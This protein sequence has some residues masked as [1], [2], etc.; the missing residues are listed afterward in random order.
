MEYF[1]QILHT[2]LLYDCPASGMQYDEEGLQSIIL[3][4]RGRLA[5]MLKTLELRGIFYIL[6]HFTY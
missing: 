6:M 2:Y 5:Q 3:A 1:D 4:G